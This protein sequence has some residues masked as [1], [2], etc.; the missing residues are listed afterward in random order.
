MSASSDDSSC[1]GSSH[2][3]HSS[4][5]RRVGVRMGVLREDAVY[6]NALSASEHDYSSSSEQSCDTVIYMPRHHDYIDECPPPM[7]PLGTSPPLYGQQRPQA[8]GVRFATTGDSSDGESVSSGGRD[9]S[10]PKC[11]ATMS[12]AA[13]IRAAAAAGKTHSSTAERATRK[14]VKRTLVEQ[15]EPALKAA[16]SKSPYRE[17]VQRTECWIDG[18]GTSN[19]SAA[20][21]RPAEHWIDGPPEFQLVQQS[22]P[23]PAQRRKKMWTE[24]KPAPP[25]RGVSLR[26][27]PGASHASPAPY[28]GAEQQRVSND[29]YNHTN[30]QDN[31][32]ANGRLQ[33]VYGCA[34]TYGAA[35]AAISSIPCDPRHGA[36]QDI[37]QTV[38]LAEIPAATPAA[39]LPGAHYK[40]HTPH[41]SSSPLRKHKTADV[42]RTPAQQRRSGDMESPSSPSQNRRECISSPRLPHRTVSTSHSPAPTT[43]ASPHDVCAVDTTPPVPSATPTSSLPAGMPEKPTDNPESASHPP[44]KHVKNFVKDWVAVHSLPNTDQTNDPGDA[45]AKLNDQLPSSPAHTAP[46]N[47]TDKPRKHHR[48]KTHLHSHSLPTSSHSTPRLKKK[49]KSSLLATPQKSSERVSA[50]VESVTG[51]AVPLNTEQELG[52]ATTAVNNESETIVFPTPDDDEGPPPAYDTCVS[53]IGSVG[54]EHLSLYDE[55]EDVEAGL[56][57]EAYETTHSEEK[58]WGTVEEVLSHHSSPE[59]KPR[60]LN[61]APEVYPGPVSIDEKTSSTARDMEASLL[62]STQ[63]DDAVAKLLNSARESIYELQM[64]A[65]METMSKTSTFNSEDEHSTLGSLPRFKTA[66]KG[67]CI[68]SRLSSR[69]ASLEVCSLDDVEIPSDP[70]ENPYQPLNACPE[71]DHQEKDVDEYSLDAEVHESVRKRRPISLRRPDGASNPDLAVSDQSHAPITDPSVKQNEE[72]FLSSMTRSIPGQCASPLGSSRE[73]DDTQTSKTPRGSKH[74]SRNNSKSPHRHSNVAS[75][76]RK[77]SQSPKRGPDGAR[78]SKTSHSPTKDHQTMASPTGNVQSPTSKLPVKSFSSKFGKSSSSKSKKPAEETPVVPEVK[79]TKSRGRSFLFRSRSSSSKSSS[80]VKT[81]SKSAQAS[82]SKGF[83]SRREKS[84]KDKSKSSTPV[85]SPDINKSKSPA[86]QSAFAKAFGRKSPKEP[87]VTSSPK[88]EHTSSPSPAKTK[89]A[90]SSS[91]KTTSSPY[92]KPSRQTSQ[93]SSR[94]TDSDSGNDSGIV[95]TDGKKKLNTS[96][97]SSKRSGRE[98]EL[99]S[100]YA[101]VTNPRISTRSSSGHGSHFSDMSSTYSTQ[102]MTSHPTTVAIK[103]DAMTVTTSTRT[104]EASPACRRRIAEVSSGY[105]SLMHDSECTTGTASSSGTQDSNSDGSTSGSRKEDIDGATDADAEKKQKTPTGKYYSIVYLLSMQ[106]QPHCYGTCLIANFTK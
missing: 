2:S 83:L 51:V 97:S 67:A 6:T 96:G 57:C 73:P 26:N 17:G 76:H 75:P 88:T 74:S 7:A 60:G 93:S 44:T 99:L 1:D 9:R 11:G 85:A 13:K 39:T 48:H 41:H 22:T 61:D 46:L 37:E 58:I 21:E 79:E 27:H 47:A 16:W 55:I 5:R 40:D 12:K 50:W 106:K 38:P 42:A 25:P 15:S 24:Q 49:L 68:L 28:A 45:S 100:P 3:S 35:P 101:T 36:M 71:V 65:E 105:E 69:N 18:P 4:H 91:V 19:D 52:H 78:S 90:S 92:N 32:Y 102:L 81:S 84:P 94:N 63:E 77:T 64:E 53:D 34:K 23:S 59:R 62:E 82:P 70:L 104:I 89:T 31:S 95:R 80:P 43:H 33:M 66:T 87:K 10:V 86:K 29:V 30:N 103:E 54:D 98:A 14:H 72:E 8:S 56:T 20:P